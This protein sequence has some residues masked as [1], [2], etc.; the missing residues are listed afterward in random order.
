MRKMARPKIDRCC[1]RISL[2]VERL[3][4]STADSLLLDWRQ[5]EINPTY[6]TT[7]HLS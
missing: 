3:R 4:P 6:Y 2:F 5:H 1:G 7:A